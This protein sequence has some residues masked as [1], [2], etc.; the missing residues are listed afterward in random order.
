M[1]S[2]NSTLI[3]LLLR[4]D[5]ISLNPEA[6]GALDIAKADLLAQ[7]TRIARMRPIF[8]IGLVTSLGFLAAT[9]L[10]SFTSL[11]TTV[12][13]LLAVPYI[14]VHTLTA[15]PLA[16]ERLPF[17]ASIP[18][19]L[20]IIALAVCALWYWLDIAAFLLIGCA[21]AVVCAI[22]YLA[23]YIL[24]LADPAFVDRAETVQTLRKS[25]TPAEL[26]KRLSDIHM[27]QF[28]I[29]TF[30]AVLRQAEDEG[31]ALQA[32]L[33]KFRVETEAGRAEA[34]RQLMAIAS[35]FR[36]TSQ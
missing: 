15:A 34:K 35:G 12:L 8:F 16:L 9:I 4:P 32:T 20:A 19:L 29:G 24:A 26:N 22:S 31:E 2:T 28:H 30:R 18:G 27:M 3:R 21:I 11:P 23:S 13:L 25:V 5:T 6:K 33:G 10:V 36:D 17:N 14:L 1:S 7:D